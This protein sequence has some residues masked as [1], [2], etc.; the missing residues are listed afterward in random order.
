[1]SQENI[2]SNKGDITNVINSE[3]KQIDNSNPVEEQNIQNATVLSETYIPVSEVCDT[4]DMSAPVRML[5]DMNRNL[6]D[7]D[8]KVRGIDLFVM[9]QLGYKDMISLCR[10]FGAEQVDAIAA[11][12]VQI[13][14]G[15]GLILSDMAGS[16]K[17]RVIAGIMRYA[18]L[19]GKKPIFI[20]EKPNLFSDIYRDIIAIGLDAGIP[21]RYRS[22]E[23]EKTIEVSRELVVSAMKED[24]NNDD[25]DLEGFDPELLFKK[26]NKEITEQAIEEY[27]KENFPDQTVKVYKYNTNKNYEEDVKGQKRFVPYILNGA[28]SKTEIKD[29]D[30]N[31]LYKGLPA[32]KN[33]E[34]LESKTIG[35]EYDCVLATYSQFSS[36]KASKKIEF[37][38]EMAKDNIVEMDECFTP[39]SKIDGISIKDIKE[40]DLVRSYNHKLNLVEYKRVNTLFTKEVKEIVKVKF[41]NGKT[42][43]VT[44]NHPYFSPDENE[45]YPINKK[46]LTFVLNI[47][48]QDNEKN[49]QMG[50]T[51]VHNVWENEGYSSGNGYGSSEKGEGILLGRMQ[52]EVLPNNIIREWEEVIGT[53]SKG[54]GEISA[55]EGKQSDE[56]SCNESQSFNEIESY[57]SSTKI[58]GW[59]RAFNF[60]STTFSNSIRL[61]YGNNCENIQKSS[62]ISSPL[63]IRHWKFGFKNSNRGGWRISQSVNSKRTGFEKRESS[64]RVRVE[65]IEILKQGSG[66]GF[67]QVCPNGVVYNIEVADNNN[68]FVD[69]I[70]VHNCHNASGTS[71]RGSILQNIVSNTRGVLFASATYAKRAD[72]MPIYAIKTDI[73]DAELTSEELIDAINKGGVAMQEILSSQL[74]AEGQMMRR[75]RSYEGIEINYMTLDETAEVKDPDF[76]LKNIH[77]SIADRFLSVIREIITF[78][79]NDVNP[80]VVSKR[81]DWIKEQCGD[82]AANDILYGSKDDKDAA[83]EL[84]KADLYNNS[85]Y[86]GIF[87]IVSQLFFSINAEAVANW[88]I[89]R[90]K[91]GKKPIIA[92]ASTMESALDYAISESEGSKIDVDFSVILKRRLAKA[93][94]YITLNEDEIADRNQL[95]VEE[96][97]GVGQL[98]Y[99]KIVENIEAL[100]MGITI[101]PIDL[102]RKRIAEAGF[103][104]EEVTGRNRIVEFDKREESGL[105]KNRNIPNAT[106]VFANFNNNVIDCLIINQAG[107]TG[108]SAHAIKTNKVTKVTYEDGIPVVPTS[109]E[110]T[111]EVKQRVMIILEAERD[112]NKE[113]QK[114]GRIF[115]TG[116][117]FNPMYDYISSAIPAQ[118]RFMM[119]LRKKLRSLDANTSSNQKQSSEILDVVDFLNEYGD[120]VVA[121]FLAKNP[122]INSMIGNPVSYNIIL[123][124]NGEQEHIPVGSIKDLAYNVT[125]KVAI[126]STEEQELF[127]NDVTS[128]YKAYQSKLIQ[129]GRWNLE[130]DSLDLQAKTLSKDAI[131]VGNSKKKSVF[132]GATF[133]EYCEIN[134]IRKPFSKSHLVNLYSSILS[135]KNIDGS[136]VDIT[137]DEYIDNLNSAID[138]RAKAEYNHFHPQYLRAKQR[139]VD[140]LPKDKRIAKIKNEA[141]RAE[142]LR[143]ETSRIV[144]LWDDKIAY[145]ENIFEKANEYKKIVSFFAPKKAV[146]YKLQKQ[147]FDGISVG[148]RMEVG[149]WLSAHAFSLRIAF[150]S[151]LRQLDISFSSLNEIKSIMS[152]TLSVYDDRQRDVVGKGILSDWDDR[153]K[154][155]V[156]QRVNRYIVTG[157]I[158]KAYGIPELSD[159]SNRLISYSTIDKKVKKG[160][161]LS[162]YFNPYELYVKIPIDA[163]KDMAVQAIGST[164]ILTFGDDD[165]IKI[166]PRQDMLLIRREK[167]KKKSY[168]IDKNN[169]LS[170]YLDTNWVKLGDY[171][172]AEIIGKDNIEKVVD[173][174]YSLG[175]PMNLR[176]E[177]FKSI[178]K[179]YDTNDRFREEDAIDELLRKYNENLEAYERE[180]NVPFEKAS[181]ASYKKM[182]EMEKELY[183]LRKEKENN[184]A[185]RFFVD[186]LNIAKKTKEKEVGKME[187]GGEFGDLKTIGD[188]QNDERF[189]YISNPTEA[190]E[191]LSHFNPKF[192]EIDELTKEPYFNNIGGLFVRYE[193]GDIVH[194][195]VYEGSVPSIEKPV[196]EIFPKNE[197]FK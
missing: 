52:K 184:K 156:S 10:A 188:L 64:E 4:L 19:Q 107:S 39:D 75:E 72:N 140:S 68:Y 164:R 40:G 83:R 191:I 110:D 152:S 9:E 141:K 113:V 85:P 8:R 178:S 104:V 14:D 162:E 166:A 186:T 109:L 48:H 97:S 30:G 95:D 90:M 55:N 183:D 93:L 71:R 32:P 194:V 101:S 153:I 133:L 23:V 155:S 76:N 187:L 47:N 69:D 120:E 34:V 6:Q 92:L 29:A 66:N 36:M 100:T 41:S 2:T 168:H 59:K 143:D 61:G 123:G 63:Q 161:L 174:L 134:N 70:L 27:R 182:E 176:F 46:L 99:E 121:K 98:N 175:F 58:Q 21:L 7:I 18:K 89:Y 15:K 24:I 1:M 173:V 196:L 158:L 60:T 56:K 79:Q 136:I 111:D 12:I 57:G 42:H 132:G 94:E 119:M 154:D 122:N 137:I 139:E 11:A 51:S 13:Q 35:D 124:E 190:K 74:V 78:V 50:N 45:Y 115:R 192:D 20:T 81:A 106:D 54:R 116:M 129:E 112:V 157:N 22:G 103:T 73:A 171:Y 16:G 82:K 108:S 163:A 37:M 114:R 135:T 77:Y 181:E 86:L 148:V 172:Q 62:I 144:G 150:P 180:Q 65:S 3:P 118:R 197:Y 128:E 38:V 28:S 170:Q 159:A 88:A 126:L 96:L 151:T 67:E 195:F 146:S 91:Q 165:I 149:T 142:A 26:G 17:G 185:L 127:Y 131:S 125:G 102:I 105:V 167:T 189:H 49:K 80:V 5:Y 33:Y 160:I 43:Y 130:V 53:Q 31:I 44:G 179:N 87:N 84:C 117:I 147:S 193:D 25:F 138:A 169:E 145:L 177:D